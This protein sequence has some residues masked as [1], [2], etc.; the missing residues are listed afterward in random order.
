MGADEGGASVCSSA[1]AADASALVACLSAKTETA[2]ATCPVAFAV[3]AAETPSSQ[4]SLGTKMSRRSI[5]GLAR[6][7]PQ[8]R[9]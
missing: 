7:D 8:S 1:A 9:R 4:T 3:A 2:A 5:I 6:P